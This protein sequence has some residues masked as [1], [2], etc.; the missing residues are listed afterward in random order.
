MRG[1]AK[2][3]GFDRRNNIFSSIE[4]SHFATP[5]F[6]I[7]QLLATTVTAIQIGCWC[8]SPL[9]T[10]TCG[11]TSGCYSTRDVGATN[12]CYFSWLR[13]RDKSQGIKITYCRAKLHSK[14]GNRVYHH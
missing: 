2:A 11:T 3:G 5:A 4:G 8:W 13:C 9:R 1:L 12:E 7:S 14:A 10:Q 6:K